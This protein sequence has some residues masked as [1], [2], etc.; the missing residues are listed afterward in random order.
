MSSTNGVLRLWTE[1]LGGPTGTRSARLP[2]I[3]SARMARIVVMI[4]WTVGMLHVRKARLL[5]SLYVWDG[6]VEEEEEEVRCREGETRGLLKT[7]LMYGRWRRVCVA[8]MLEAVVDVLEAVVV[9]GE[10]GEGEG[11]GRVVCV[12]GRSAVVWAN[13]H[14]LNN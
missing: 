2:R 6:V 1:K 4:G 8:Q 7:S 9:E 11:D 3:V 13:G 10:R 5:A 14:V 12:E